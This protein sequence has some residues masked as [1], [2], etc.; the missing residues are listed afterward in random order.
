MCKLLK[1]LYIQIVL[2][3]ELAKL[4]TEQLKKQKPMTLERAR[5][6]AKQVQERIEG[7]SKKPL[8]EIKTRK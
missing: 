8:I 1:L 3:K 6:Q 2:F 4:G 7:K 5:M